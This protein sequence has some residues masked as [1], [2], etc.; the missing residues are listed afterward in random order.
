MSLAHNHMTWKRW[1]SWVSV[2]AFANALGGLVA[3]WIFGTFTD[4]IFRAWFQSV[5]F[6]GSNRRLLEYT[7][8][9]ISGCGAGVVI[10][11]STASLFWQ[12]LQKRFLVWWC[13][14]SLGSAALV[15]PSIALL[16]NI[17]IFTWA[18]PDTLDYLLFALSALIAGSCLAGSQ[19]IVL[20]HQITLVRWWPLV[21][22]VSWLVVISLFYLLASAFH[23]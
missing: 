21:G 15:L 19:A 22:G 12:T 16:L 4:H 17:V 10:G 7:I 18:P 14:A 9:L 13:F 8:L 3:L 23:L 5:T 20:R 1:W 11:L 2:S 6:S